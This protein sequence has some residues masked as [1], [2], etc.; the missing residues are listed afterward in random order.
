[1]PTLPS[2]S[3]AARTSSWTGYSARLFRQPQAAGAW[4]GGPDQRAGATGL[5][6][7]SGYPVRPFR[8]DRRPCPVAVRAH[9]TVTFEA[10]KPGLV[11]PEAAPY[12][13]R[14]H[15]RPIGI[16]AMVRR[17]HPASYQMLTKAIAGAFPEAAPGWHKGTAG[18]ILI[19]GGSEGLTGAP[20]LAARA[21]LRAGGGLISVAAPHGLCRDIK[22]DC[23]DIMTRALGPAGNVRWSPALLEELLPFLRQCGAMVL[24]PGI[25]REPETAASYR[26]VDVPLAPSARGGRGRAAR[27]RH[28]SRSVVFPAG[29]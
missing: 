29:L 27:P 9:A 6:F 4:A 17:E 2:A 23:P 28:A 22:A 15:I 18:A 16:P 12:T 3:G 26:P 24:G 21:A 13:G 8:I 14:L 20:H 1:M 11:L 5:H 25:G 7:F 19:V 10:A